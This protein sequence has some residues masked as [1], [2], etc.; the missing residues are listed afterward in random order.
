MKPSHLLQ[1]FEACTLRERALIA[2]T[3]LVLLYVAWHGWLMAPL[4][5]HQATLSTELKRLQGSIAATDAEIAR[6]A[7]GDNGTREAM[8]ERLAREQAVQAQLEARLEA[9]FAHMVD[10]VQMARLVEEVLAR[11]SDLTLL[12]LQSLPVRALGRGEADG[13][14]VYRHGLVVEFEGSYLGALRYLRALEGLPWGFHWEAVEFEVLE[15]PRGR[16]RITLHTLSLREG[17]IGV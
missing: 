5:A 10:P 15:H 11:Q 14:H 4:N 3:V 7:R 6:L 8:R 17:W 13:A 9:R 1:R 16:M 12:G 2:L